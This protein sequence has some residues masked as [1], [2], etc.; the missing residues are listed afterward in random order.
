MPI[1]KPS[2]L[3][4]PFFQFNGHLQTIVPSAKRKIEDVN[5][6][7][8]RVELKDG[9][10]LDLDWSITDNDSERVVIISHG[11]EG[12][13]DR[14]YCKGIA[15]IF[16]EKGWDALA[17]NCRSC[18]GE[19][20]RLPR[21]YH[22]GDV[23]DFDVVVEEARKK[24]Y[25]KIAFV[26]FSMGGAI[27]MNALGTPEFNKEN[28]V[29][30]VA[31]STPIELQP[32]SD[33]LEKRTKRI[34]N[35]KFFK[36]LKAKVIAKSKIMRGIDT[37]PLL[38]ESF[39][40]LR[41]FDEAYTAPLHGFENAAEFYHQASVQRRIHN[42]QHPVLILNA[43]NDPFLTKESYPVEFASQSDYISLEIPK[44]GG[45]VGFSIVNSDFTYAELRALSFIQKIS[46]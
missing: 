11:L 32:S 28:I 9:D 20:N 43:K 12:G 5:Y 21:F 4:V 24:G 26:G 3:K 34:Y 39:K 19:L 16:N 41:D 44:K 30:G 14:H 10:F 17:W 7:R 42:I 37:T 40:T 23:I 38:D 35:Q 6:Q 2:K 22:H 27:L 33:E 31:I 18:S 45:H 29:G 15:K 36:K 46:L 25:K 1:V 13:A 8:Q